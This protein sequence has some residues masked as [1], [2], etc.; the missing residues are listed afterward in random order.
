MFNKNKFL[1]SSLIILAVFLVSFF[2][3][4]DS[5]KADCDSRSNYSCR[6]NHSVADMT[7]QAYNHTYSVDNTSVSVANNT[8]IPLKT[9]TEWDEFKINHPAHIVIT[10]VPPCEGITSVSFYYRGSV[11]TYN[12]VNNFSTSECWL[13]RNLGASQVATAI[14]DF[15]SYGDFFQW[16]RLD[17]GHQDR[18]SLTTYTLSTSDVPGHNLFI[19]TSGGGEPDWRDPRNDNLWQ[20]ETGINNPCP[21]GFRVPTLAELDS[22]R[23]SWSSN[24]TSGA[25]NSPLKWS[26]G[27]VRTNYDGPA[28]DI[29]LVGEGSYG[30]VW[31][32][33][34]SGSV[35]ES[36][37]LLTA[38]AGANTSYDQK[39]N[40]GQNVR[41]IKGD[42]DII[43]HN[44][45][46]NSPG[47]GIIKGQTFQT[48]AH[49]DSGSEVT[50]LAL[51][52]YQFTGWSDH[53]FHNPR[54]DTNVTSDINVTA[55][56][57]KDAEPV[58]PPPP[59]DSTTY[60]LTYDPNGGTLTGES[61]QTVAY[62]DDGRTVSVTPRPGHFFD[63]WSDGVTTASRTDRDVTSDINVFAEYTMEVP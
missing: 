35:S 43:Y 16:G 32:S 11:E 44:L 55:L 4:I 46:Y 29:P 12:T 23:Q 25:F 45:E 61:P 17:D 33:S 50:A 19:R 39:R 41:C 47:G 54:I 7:V 20:G 59:S 22:E 8:F 57:S 63:K 28:G 14:D 34:V 37:Y 13:D 58:P 10:E 15:S 21:A 6:I 30:Y 60:T 2:I 52:G 24:N 53:I 27:G 26:A 36:S 1:S 18:D 5:A 38:L 49:G 42:E 31:S 48:V 40:F 3:Q 51:R 62:G 56:F 9:A